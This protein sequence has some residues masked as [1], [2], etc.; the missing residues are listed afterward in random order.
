[1]H[2]NS[3]LAAV[4]GMGIALLILCVILAARL[5][6]ER[7]GLTINVFDAE[8]LQAAVSELEVKR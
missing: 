8:T 5:P 7:C 4:I 2:R 1:M 3:L 6:I